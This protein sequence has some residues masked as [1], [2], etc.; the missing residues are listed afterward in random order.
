MIF[1]NLISALEEKYGLKNIRCDLLP[2]GVN[3]T[4]LI[5]SDQGKYIF[6][7]YRASHRSLMQIQ[8]EIN[9]LL[10][11]KQNDVSVSYPIPDF[12]EAFIQHIMEPGENKH[13]VLFNYA[14]GSTVKMLN[15]QQLQNLGKEMAKFHT[16]S[17]QM[18]MGGSRWR[19]DFE[20]TLFHPL[21]LLR[22]YFADLV[23]DYSWLQ[24]SALRSEKVL[25]QFDLS[26][27]AEG[28]C[29]YDFLP[30]NF[31]F[32][33]DQVTFFDFDFMGSGW[34]V[35][36]VMSFWQHLIL[37]VYNRRMSLEDAKDAYAVFLISYYNVRPFSEA[38][39]QSVPYLSLGFWLFY[40]GFHT[41]HEHFYRF[42]QPEYLKSVVRF[43]RHLVK[44]Y[45]TEE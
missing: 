42:L 14:P 20:T 31:H 9:L 44:E 21:E 11:L 5:E 24:E 37:D 33:N 41:T 39:L 12:S 45:W 1:M 28:Y 38:E 18:N 30:K 8:E 26:D 25:S 2:A 40:M 4:Y 7:G 15:H 22:P 29:H 43:L 16:V 35:N 23:E 34:L 36:D 10:T 27:F 32:E 17:S 13:F 6:R 3:R 19:F